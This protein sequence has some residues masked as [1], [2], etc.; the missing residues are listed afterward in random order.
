MTISITGGDHK[1][2]KVHIPAR[3]K[4]VRPTLSKI[5]EAVFNILGQDLSSYIFIDTFAG[6]GIMGMEALSRGVEKTFF[7]E[8]NSALIK[9]LVRNLKS[10]PSSCYEVLEGDVF[11][12]L[13]SFTL[14]P[15]IYYVDPPHSLNNEPFI[16][17]FLA[18]FAVPPSLIILE[19]PSSR[20]FSIPDCYTLLKKKQYGTICLYFLGFFPKNKEPS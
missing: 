18:S 5:R 16:L 15:A 17:D 7:F 14:T 3:T 8:N 4:N 9:I 1:G 19:T 20:S 13:P 10:F 2:L 11:H 12:L 6:S